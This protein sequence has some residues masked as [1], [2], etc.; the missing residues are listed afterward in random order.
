VNP[1]VLIAMVITAVAALAAVALAAK[2]G[3]GSDAIDAGSSR[4]DGA[5]LPSG[6]RAPDFDLRD[7]EGKAVSMRQ[8]RGRPVIVTFLY[9]TCQNSCPAMAQVVKGA[10]ND[11]GS[12]VPALAVAVDPPR[13]NAERARKFLSTQRVIGRLDFVLGSRSQL[14][15]VWKGFAI[16]PQSVSQEHQARFTLVDKRGLQRIGFPGNKAT[17]EAIAHDVALL[18]RE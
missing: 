11:L 5:L 12:D 14:Q 8:F 17:P 10:L 15:P 4:F 16:Q 7:Q 13:D 9:T 2:G 18:E 3:G 1:R 6:V